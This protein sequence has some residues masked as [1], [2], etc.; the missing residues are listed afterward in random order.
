MG[1]SDEERNAIRSNFYSQLE[2]EHQLREERAI[3]KQQRKR[4][5]EEQNT[6]QKRSEIN[7]YKSQL[8]RDFYKKHG[9]SMEKDPTGRDMWLSPTERVNRQRKKKGR[10]KKNHFA[11]MVKPHL[12]NILMYA[13]IAL[14]AIILGL[15]IAK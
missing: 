8:R 3:R 1:L 12:N 14:F 6:G 7:A 5:K 11:T 9:Y 13:G 15:I 10:R 4:M 2:E